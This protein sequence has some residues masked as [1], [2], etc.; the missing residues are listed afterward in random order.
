MTAL[1][2]WTQGL[3]SRIDALVVQVENHD[4]QADSAIRRI[5]QGVARARVQLARVE[6]DGRF[7]EQRLGDARQ[8]T[9]VWRE[10]ARA[11]A[12]DERALEC[13]R[14][15]HRTAAEAERLEEAA[16][17]HR[18]MAATLRRDLTELERRLGELRERRASFRT[19]AVRAEAA[20]LIRMGDAECLDDVF[21]RWDVSLTET[22]V[23]SGRPSESSDPF[24]E[25]IE[26]AE[27]QAELRRE[28]AALRGESR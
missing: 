9:D 17:E 28:L 3:A 27:Q 20:E 26:R 23:R 24:A 8:Q 2:R 15:S 12:D 14:R 25:G 1:I 7:L 6:R 5:E 22:E 10:R 16:E 21:E 13:L 4:A 11:E 18:T 19:R